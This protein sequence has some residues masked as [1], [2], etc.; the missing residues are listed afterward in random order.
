MLPLWRSSQVHMNDVASRRKWSAESPLSRPT[1]DG[2]A[3]PG[4]LPG[5]RESSTSNLHV[6]SNATPLGEV[7]GRTMHSEAMAWHA[8]YGAAPGLV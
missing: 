4:T 6:Q 5:T 7:G 8:R 3:G 2:Y 1:L